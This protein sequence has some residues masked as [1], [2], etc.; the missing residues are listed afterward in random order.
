[1]LAARLAEPAAV[2]AAAQ[3]DGGA[4]KPTAEQRDAAGAAAGGAGAIG[5]FLSSRQGQAVKREVVR[6]VF[7]LLKKAV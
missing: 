6:G 5:A 3:G 2:P 7:G 1:M 4:P